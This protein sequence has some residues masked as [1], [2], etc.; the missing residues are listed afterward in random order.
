MDC[1]VGD[2]PEAFFWCV[3]RV[4]RT[5][6]HMPLQRFAVVRKLRQYFTRCGVADV[7]V[8]IK[9]GCH[10]GFVVRHHITAQLRQYAAQC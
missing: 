10:H 9:A 8:V 3:C 5:K 2:F 6:S 1:R 4:S 7:A